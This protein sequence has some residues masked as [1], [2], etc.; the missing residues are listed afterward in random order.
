MSKQSN[1]QLN[2]L[3]KGLEKKCP[4]E[5]DFLN[6][7]RE[8]L[9]SVLPYMRGKTKYKDQAI[10]ERL[11]EP[12][13]V[14]MFRV[15]WQDD[16]NVAQVNRGYRVQF[17]NFLGPYKGG[18]R[19]HPTVSLGVLKFL[20]FEQI[21]K[22]ALTGLP[23]GAGKGGSDFDPKGKSDGEVMRFCQSFMVELSR[24]I[25]PDVD[26]PAGDIGVGS[27]EVGFM[28]GMYRRLSNHVD[29]TFTGKGHGW[30]GS[31][32]R[33]E[34]T[35]YGAVYFLENML[36]KQNREIDGHSF[37]VSGSGNVA[38]HCAEKIIER[39]GKVLTLSDSGGFVH[40]PDG[41]TLEKLEALK[42]LK[43]VRRGR[44]KEYAEEHGAVFHE[45]KKPWALKA[46][47]AMPCATQNEITEKDAAKLVKH[48]VFAV[49]EGANMPTTLEAIHLLQESNVLFAPG[50]AANAGG[51]AV[52]GLE[53]AQ[54][55]QRIHWTRKRV[56]DEL[57]T[58]MQ[59]IHGKCV[60]YGEEKGGIN[61][62]KG[63]NLAGFKRVADAMVAQGFL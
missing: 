33:P 13:R 60:Q 30:G 28:Y 15:V 2:E 43:N 37:L 5:P 3:I 10:V 57:H 7:V 56:D 50:K 58:I 21:F 41:F 59:S 17:N 63:A 4:N 22:N 23:L 42:E 35:G 1:N 14:V 49:V 55:S 8:V 54:N 48:G 9:E 31:L 20:G 38:Q 39:G 27:R 29:G 6:A 32:L 36:K 34:A 18:I 61:Y 52:S 53:M 44:I 51:V 16:R 25:G 12:D 47:V 62:L 19:F 11:L 26:V 45:G 40:E 24:H 46:D